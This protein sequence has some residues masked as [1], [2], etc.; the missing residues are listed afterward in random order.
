MFEN[1]NQI[2]QA[3][4]FDIGLFQEVL[5][6]HK[7]NKEHPHQIELLANE[8]WKEFSFAKNSVVANFDHGN[9]IMSRFPIVQENIL[10]LSLN[11]FENRCAVLTKIEIPNQAIYCICTHLSLRQST[12]D[13]QAKLIMEFINKHIGPEEPVLLGGDFNDWNGKVSKYFREVG[14]FESTEESESI[15]SFPSF[16]PI[17]PLDR[18]MCRNL[19]IKF[20]KSGSFKTFRKYSDHLPIFCNLE[21]PETR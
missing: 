20:M 19:K 6:H 8:K 10:N 4:D 7:Y 15:K 16:F 3:H 5:G 2:L 21:L 14:R 9:A 12:R 13:R 17:L 18:L 1:L 11:R